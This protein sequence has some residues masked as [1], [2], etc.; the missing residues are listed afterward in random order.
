MNLNDIRTLHTASLTFT[1]WGYFLTGNNIELYLDAGA[2]IVID[3]NG[4]LD[5]SNPCSQSMIIFIGG[6]TY[7]TCNGAGPSVISWEDMIIGGGSVNAELSTNSPICEGSTLIVTSDY[8]GAAGTTT[9]G[10]ST[11]GVSFELFDEN[12]LLV[13]NGILTPSTPPATYNVNFAVGGTHTFTLKVTTYVGSKAFV[14]SETQVATVIEDK[15]PPVIFCADPDNPYLADAGQCYY[16]VPQND[17]QLLPPKVDSFWLGL[18]GNGDIYGNSGGEPID[19]GEGEDGIWR[20]YVEAPDNIDWWNIWF[21]DHP[22]DTTRY[23]VIKMGFWVRPLVLHGITPELYYVVNW[24]TPD[25]EGTGYPQPTDED[26]IRRSPVNGPVMLDPHVT[27]P[28]WIELKYIIP[29]YNPE[30]VSVD[31]WGK[32]VLID[33]DPPMPPPPGSPLFQYWD[34]SVNFG[35]IIV[36][37]CLPKLSSFDPVFDD[38]CGV[39][40]VTNSFNNESTLAGAQLPVGTTEITWTVTDGAGNSASCTQTVIVKCDAYAE[41]L[42]SEICVGETTTV[43]PTTGTWISSDPEIA[44]V[45]DGLVAGITPGS[46]TLTFTSETCSCTTEVIVTVLPLPEVTPVHIHCGETTGSIIITI[47]DIPTVESFFDIC[48]DGIPQGSTNSPT[49]TVDG[50]SA[51]T[52]FVFINP[53]PDIQIL[54]TG[55]FENLTFV[56]DDTFCPGC[57]SRVELLYQPVTNST[58]GKYYETI[59]GAIDEASDGDVILVCTGTYLEDLDGV[60]CGKNLTFSPGS[61]PGCA[62]VGSI[63]LNAGDVL[64]AD[65]DGTTA[66]TGY[67]QW[68]ATNTVT[69]G[70]ATLS[71]NLGY[72]PSLGDNFTIIDNQ[73]AGAVTGTFTGLPE[74]SAFLAGGQIF[75]VSYM[76]GTGNDVVLTVTNTCQSGTLTLTSTTGTD[77]QVLCGTGPIQAIQYQVG[78]GATSVEVTGL[79]TSFTVNFSSSTNLLTIEG[80]APVGVYNYTVT[81]LGAEDPCVNAT[82]TGTITVNEIPEV[83]I[84]DENLCVGSTTNVDPATG[85]AWSTSDSDVATVVDGLVTAINPGVATLTFVDETTSCSNSL[86]VWVWDPATITLTSGDDAPVACEDGLAITPIVYTYGGDAVTATFDPG[87]TGLTG[88]IDVVSKTITITGTLVASGTFTV[89]AWDAVSPCPAVSLTGYGTVIPVPVLYL[90]GAGGSNS[91][92][93]CQDTPI[94][95]ISYIFGGGATGVD[96]VLGTGLESL[97]ATVSGTT[98][99]LSGTPTGYG[100]FTYTITTTGMEPCDPLTLTGTI[101]VIEKAILE[102]QT[103]N[104]NQELCGPGAIEDIVYWLN[105]GASGATVYGLTPGLSYSFTPATPDKPK[106]E[107]LTIFGTVLETVNYTIVTSGTS[108]PPCEELTVTGTITVHEIP[109][110]P[111]ITGPLSVCAYSEQVYEASGTGAVYYWSIVGGTGTSSTNSITITWDAAG[112]G[113]VSVTYEDVNGCFPVN[114]ATITVTVNELPVPTIA[115]MAIVCETEVLVYD[116]EAGMSNYVWGVTGGEI[117]SGQGTASITVTWGEGPAMGTITVTY[118]DENGCYPAE[119]SMKE[120]QINDTATLSLTAESGAADQAICYNTAIEDIVYAIGGGATGATVTFDPSA[121][122]LGYVVTGTEVH[123][124]GSATETVTYEIWTTGT[125]TPCTEATATGTITVYPLTY[126]SLNGLNVVCAYTSVEYSTDPDM[127]LYQW[128]V[129]GG[130]PS[131]IDTQTITVTWGDDTPGSV[132]VTY[133]DQNGCP[134]VPE[135]MDITIYLPSTITLTS[136][137]TPKGESSDDQTICLGDAIYPITY[138]VDLGATGLDVIGLEPGLT[139][140]IETTTEGIV[141]TI[142]GTTDTDV[143]YTITT[144]GSIAPCEE[145]IAEGWITV[146]LKPEIVLCAKDTVINTSDGGTGDCFGEL[147][148]SEGVDYEFSGRPVPEVTYSF[149]GETMTGTGAWTGVIDLPVG[150]NEVTLTAVNECGVASCVFTV[151][152]VDDED[153]QISCVGNQSVVTDPGEATYTH[154]NALWDA[155]SWDNCSTM[156]PTTT[157]VLSGVTSGSGSTL[158]GTSF[159]VGTTH[160]VWTVTDSSDSTAVCEYDVLVSDNQAPMIQCAFQDTVLS[161]D[162]GKCYYK[163]KGHEFDPLSW[164]DNVGIVWYGYSLDGETWTWDDEE[165]CMQGVN[166]PTGVNTIWWRVKDAAGNMA[167]CNMIVTVV[168]EELP[169]F[170][171]CGDTFCVTLKPTIVRNRFGVFISATGYLYDSQIR[172][173]LSDNCTPQAQIS[174]WINRSTTFTDKDGGANLV[175][176]FFTDGAGN[177]D[178]CCIIIDV[179]LPFKKGQTGA[180]LTDGDVYSDLNMTIYPNPTRG[181]LFVELQNLNDPKVIAKVY[182]ATGAMVLNREFTTDK[183]VEIDLTGNVS[184]MYMLQITADQRQF[185]R[186]IILDNR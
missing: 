41:I 77:N 10:G 130:T 82:M 131:A 67:D 40:T 161:A 37:E 114:P 64:I 164:S 79:A 51:G 62:T 69:L 178:S 174:W 2:V 35:G 31:I 129:V 15:I 11:E 28:Q 84:D 8:T 87:V 74:G 52:H 55:L 124:F 101:N 78:G 58:Q 146:N 151:E 173:L 100:T 23:K 34:P 135:S 104:D 116:T 99:T 96:I 109:E 56:S 128:L 182:S 156:T 147:S 145:V 76:G 75:S 6:D 48:V 108:V 98:A 97:S 142:T 159:N 20:H 65:I 66:C 89:T 148:L 184:G 110:D 138:L 160:V 39:V 9:P 137:D 42:K 22:L 88:D 85:G 185:T 186:K 158:S 43:S 179:P 68:T 7:S 1:N 162:P 126:A 3:N 177:L 180:Q 93:I 38:S 92:T 53:V 136:G 123:I 24:S 61:S 154:L 181:K 26:F 60:S 12:N 165:V 127:T 90:D 133:T 125:S 111:E 183:L 170:A 157:F 63:A 175:K 150:I 33:N 49:F 70:G 102:L 143:H 120:V 19:T 80:F 25:W 94:V 168:D 103:A 32:N 169:K 81:T 45:V 17:T 105:G 141:V 139:F 57:M 140:D 119:P 163:V 29:D 113:T 5:V 4:S 71:V 21:Y 115:G 134:A 95:D 91:Q 112:T 72:S 152:V 47:P 14:M 46:A 121:T 54:P 149:I 155:G 83:S 36:H 144:D 73:G 167:E 44:S 18:D 50:L 171:G 59:Q 30:W 132:S 13:Q 106:G 122:G 117:T 166:I 118:M 172:P 176:I 86:Q 16:T 27:T 107:W 153:P